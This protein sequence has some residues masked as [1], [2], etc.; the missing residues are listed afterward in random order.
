MTLALVSAEMKNE[1]KGEKRMRT[2]SIMAWALIT[3]ATF[4]A[5]A[6]AGKQPSGEEKV[7]TSTPGTE[8]KAIGSAKAGD[9]TVTLASPTGEI[10][11]GENNL[12]LSFTDSSGKP[13]DV[14][15]ASLKF[16]MAAMGMMAEMNDPATVTK[17]EK[18]GR[19]HAH[20][21]IE[22]SGTWEAIVD[23]QGPG[24]PGQAKMSVTAK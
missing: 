5:A 2:K 17:A 10:K 22:T 16:H 8:E 9:L 13:V 20:V 7:A 4:L 1:S 6:C 3:T 23:Y 15:A 24:G 21:K 19:H 12:T 18:P 14:A 11:E